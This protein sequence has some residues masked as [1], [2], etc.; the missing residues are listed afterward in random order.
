[1]GNIKKDYSYGDA[2][3]AKKRLKNL[4]GQ[5]GLTIET[6]SKLTRNQFRLFLPI[7]KETLL[8]K[9]GKTKS[10]EYWRIMHNEVANMLPEKKGLLNLK[11]EVGYE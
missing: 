5:I 9:A 8:V 3:E 4:L 1:M 7:A 10:D 2:L 6:W 11:S